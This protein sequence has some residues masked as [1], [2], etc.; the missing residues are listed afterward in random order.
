MTEK[1]DK[2]PQRQHVSK[3]K[4]TTDAKTCLTGALSP[5]V[6]LRLADD[7]IRLL[8]ITIIEMERV[9]SDHTT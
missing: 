8:A 5:V 9:K 4:I 6:R 7:P 3:R 2:P 1:Q